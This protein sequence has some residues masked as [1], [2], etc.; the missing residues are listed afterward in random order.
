MMKPSTSAALRDKAAVIFCDFG[1]RSAALAVEHHLLS[2]GY[3]TILVHQEENDVANYFLGISKAEKVIEVLAG[4]EFE[5][6]RSFV[7]KIG[8]VVLHIAQSARTL[9][10]P[11][12]RGALEMPVKTLSSDGYRSLGIISHEQIVNCPSVIN[13][14]FSRLV[15]TLNDN[16][17]SE[18]LSANTQTAL[19]LPSGPEP[20][21]FSRF[22][23]LIFEAQA[24]GRGLCVFSPDD[25][26]GKDFFEGLSA[27]L[28]A[29]DRTHDS[30][31]DIVRFV[32]RSPEDVLK[33]VAGQ[34]RA[35]LV[36]GG[37]NRFGKP[38]AYHA[39]AFG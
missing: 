17:M 38:D 33:R 32:A 15:V 3:R 6:T 2:M 30:S 20:G 36:C 9:V 4:S 16:H 1:T 21:F 29:I 14:D 12:I 18:W 19:V 34:A 11:A 27:W 26:S 13:T 24:H 39:P 23:T 28:K 22:T 8:D 35:A 10:M 37:L 5:P 25:G 7:K 31:L